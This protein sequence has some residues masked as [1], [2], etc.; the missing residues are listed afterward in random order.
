[1]IDTRNDIMRLLDK[2]NLPEGGNQKLIKIE[3][4]FTGMTN[5]NYICS[6]LNGEQFVVR[7]PGKGTDL[8]INRKDEGQNQDLIT[9]LHLNTEVLFYDDNTGVKITRF[10]ENIFLQKGEVSNKIPG[11]CESLKRLHHS[12]IHFKNKFW[13]FDKLRLYET[14]AYGLGI[15]FCNG[16]FDVKNKVLKHETNLLKNVQWKPCHNDPVLENFLM[17]LYSRVYLIDWEY[18][19]M[20]DPM[21]DIASF[22]LENDLNDEEEVLLWRC[23]WGNEYPT[24]AMLEVL[25]IYKIC[26]DL[27]WYVWAKIKEFQGADLSNY[28]QSRLNR[29]IHSY[30]VQ[31]E[32][33][34]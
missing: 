18:S 32:V 8:M 26:Q 25:E 9:A 2:A 27:L 11:V 12:G 14:I 23:Y 31:Y 24:V 16:F 13:V 6:F 33:R 1:M 21:W 3:K 30:N 15:F 34:S 10:V 17:D 4:N 28:A 20:N 5:D 29:A 22:A 7:L 19:G